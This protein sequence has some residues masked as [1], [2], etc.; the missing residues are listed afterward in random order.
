M[1]STI[2]LIEDNLEMAD[3]IASIL[4]LAGYKVLRAHN[5]KTGA[6][7]AQQDHPDLILC[8]VMMPELDG[9]GVLHILS[10]DP[11]TAAIPFVFLT[12]KADKSDFREGMNLGADDYLTKPFDDLDLL[13]VIETRLR[14]RA[15]QAPHAES[16]GA[17]NDPKDLSRILEDRPIRTFRKKELLFM[18]GQHPNDLFYIRSGSVKTY[19]MNYDGKMLITGMHRDGEYIGYVPLLQ[20]KPYLVNAEALEKTEV[21][22]IPKQAFLSMMYSNKQIARMFIGILS[23][24]LSDTEKRLLEIAYQSVRQRVAGALLEIESKYSPPEKLPIS[25]ARKDIAGMIGTAIESLNRTLGDFRDEGLIEIS[26]NGLRIVNRPK[27]E[28]MLQNG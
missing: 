5:G 24:N 18:E 2:L 27:L 12:A 1:M 10:S 8:D 7:L 11:E 21:S 16:S 4:E 14:K 9:Y 23:A 19:R 17:V 13:R 6:V 3:N 20:D 26:L 25:L 22:V 28:R 15:A